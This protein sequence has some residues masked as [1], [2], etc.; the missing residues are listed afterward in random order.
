[1][2][3]LWWTN[4]IQVFIDVELQ[5]IPGIGVYFTLAPVKYLVHLLMDKWISYPLF[6][7]L[8][9]WGVF[10]SIDYQEEEIYQSYSVQA[11]LLIAAQEKGQW[12]E[13][14]DF[15]KAAKNLIRFHI[16]K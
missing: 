11:D 4:I 13:R 10:N 8:S 3:R 9:R 14:E 15:K 7:F 1:M 2:K 12:N 5:T 16:P 6:N